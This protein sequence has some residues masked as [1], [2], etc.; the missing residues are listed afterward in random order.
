MLKEYSYIQK[1]FIILLFSVYC[2]SLSQSV[3]LES[4]LGYIEESSNQYRNTF[5]I[6]ARVLLPVSESSQLYI[7]PYWLGGFGLDAGAW[8]RLPLTIQDLEGFHSYVG[9]GLSLT[10]A[11]FGFAL[12]AA[13]SYDFSDQ[14]ALVLIYTHR[15]LVTPQLSQVFDLSLGINF[16]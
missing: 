5:K 8:F 12:N 4:G 6:G 2:L 14:A 11:R 1:A 16:K 3:T 9:G 7:N 15:P 13:I 10:Q